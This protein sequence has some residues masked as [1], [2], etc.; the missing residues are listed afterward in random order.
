MG[1]NDN[2]NEPSKLIPDEA[3]TEVTGGTLPLPKEF[4]HLLGEVENPNAILCVNYKLRVGAIDDA[5]CYLYNALQADGSEDLAQQLKQL[6]AD[7][8][9]GKDFPR[10]GAKLD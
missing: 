4:Y 1:E 8:Y 7:S 6:Y 2:P 9:D 3:L 10:L 5:Y